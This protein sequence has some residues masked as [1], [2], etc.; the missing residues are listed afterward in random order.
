MGKSDRLLLILSL[1]RFRKNLRAS[2]LAKECEV[3]ER[4]IYRDILAL[5]EARV[6]IYFDQGYK[7]LTDAFLPPL[8]FTVDELITLYLGIRSDPV[9]SVDC[10]RKSAKHALAKLE[11]LIPEKIRA[12]YERS[13]EG[14]TVELEKESP[15]RPVALL[16]E[17]LK[18]AIQ[19]EKKIKLHYASVHSSKVIELVP[20]ALLY[21]RGNWY[22]VGLILK[23]ISYFQLDMIKNVT[24]S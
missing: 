5:S 16:F 19:S 13:K 23:N 14:I 8:N 4:T 18:Q 17:L 11:S 24:F 6:P 22:L 3:S 10:L 7:L 15:P 2:D 1:L 9:Q 12:D 21:K 20:K